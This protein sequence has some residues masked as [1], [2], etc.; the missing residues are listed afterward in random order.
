VL[1]VGYRVLD[2]G[3]EVEAPGPALPAHARVAGAAEGGLQV[4]HEEAVDPDGPGDQATRHPL[5]PVRVAGVDDA[6]QSELAVVGHGHALVLVGEGLEGEDRPEH[7]VGH[8]LATRG[9]VG[10]K[11]RPVVEPTEVLVRAATDDRL[12]AGRLGPLDEAVHPLEVLTADLGAEVGG[13]VPGVALVEGARPFD[14]AVQELVPHGRLDEEARPGEA[15]LPGVVV[16]LDGLGHRG[17]QVGVGE[18]EHRRLAAE[19]EADRGQVLAGGGGHDPAGRHRPGEADAAHPRMA[20]EGVARLLAD[21]LDDVEHAGGQARFGGYVSQERGGEGAPLGGLQHHGAPRGQR[22]SDLPRGEHERSVPRGDEH[23]HA[24]G[25]PGDVVGVAPGL[26][27]RV[28]EL[29]QP[30]GEEGEVVGHPGHDAASVG[31]QEGTVVSG[32]DDRQLLES[33]LDAVSDA[34]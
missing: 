23:G 26:E 2:V 29:G 19:F 24:R 25:V 9:G 17:V 15:D 7:L 22:R 5:G 30:V 27:V 18:D 32:L 33:G 4:P 16:L 10:E 1:R 34:V 31:A 20:D 6:G 28:T 12:E 11:R 21:A 3:V 13:L 14:E 8:D